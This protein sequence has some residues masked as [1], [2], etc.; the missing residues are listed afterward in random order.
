MKKST[1]TRT[2]IKEV[3]AYSE[4]FKWEV[5]Q[6]VLSGKLSK[7]TARRVYGIAGNSTILYWMRKFSGIEDYR[8]GGVVSTNLSEMSKSKKEQELEARVAELEHKLKKE[9]LRADLWQKMIEV[10]EEDLKLPI[11]KKYGAKPLE[12]SKQKEAGQ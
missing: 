6:Q 3:H 7:E 8:A 2:T 5:V 11:Q 1:K 4:E 12:D 10:A 9:Q